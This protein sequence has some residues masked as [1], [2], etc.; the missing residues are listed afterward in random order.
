MY[1]TTSSSTLG[2][3]DEGPYHRGAMLLSLRTVVPY[4]QQEL[5]STN[6]EPV[7]PLRK[8]QVTLAALGGNCIRKSTD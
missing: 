3:S 1:G 8:V 6:V 7:A 4:Y 5:R 2:N